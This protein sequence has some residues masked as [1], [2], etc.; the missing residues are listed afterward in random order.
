[1]QKRFVSRRFCDIVRLNRI[2]KS[3]EFLKL[4]INER[5]MLKFAKLSDK[6]HAP[7]RGSEHA[8]GYDLRRY[9]YF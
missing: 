7:T 3:L 2:E 5:N 1:M 9:I 4:V 8:A 6:A